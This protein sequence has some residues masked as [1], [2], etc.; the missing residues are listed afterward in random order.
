MTPLKR[1][2]NITRNMFN[3]IAKRYDL[4]N[5]LLSF[6]MDYYW[7]KKAIK[8]ITNNPRKILDVATGTADF[9]ISAANLKNVEIIGIDIAEGMLNIGKEKIQKKKLDDIISLQI[10]D[11]EDLPFNDNYFDAITVGF[12]VRNFE[13]LEKGLSEMYRTV[14]KGGI[15]VILEPSIPTSFP[16]NQIYNIYFHYILPFL[17]KLISKDNN[18]YSYL[19]ASVKEFPKKKIFMGYLKKVGFINS[20]HIPLTFG[21]VDLYI[22]IK[23]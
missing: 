14:N 17:G 20:Q 7:R 3:N 12:G 23:Q 1:N 4:L 18:A 22:A 11:S 15:V 9:A 21:I 19:P 8:H 6:G 2:K 16:L 5:H 13:N 10:A